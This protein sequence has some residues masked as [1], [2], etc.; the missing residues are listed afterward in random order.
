[1]E[2]G[3]AYQKEH[4]N[5]SDLNKRRDYGDANWDIGTEIQAASLLTDAALR[6]HRPEMARAAVVGLQHLSPKT[7]YSKSE[8]WRVRAKFAELEGRRLDALAMYRTAIQERPANANVGDHDELAEN[9]QRLWKELG[10]TDEG[11]P[12]WKMNAVAVDVAKEEWAKPAKT[13]AAWAL[14]D[15][16]GKRWQLGDFQGK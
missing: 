10:G 4:T 12:L 16:Q 5:D 7:G 3:L 6:L 15:V 2:K 11:Y 8:L 13:M 1:M 14:P 9:E